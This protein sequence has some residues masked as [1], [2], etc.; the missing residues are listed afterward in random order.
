[1]DR[2]TRQQCD[3]Y[4]YID[5]SNIRLACAK[6]LGIRIDFV[7]LLNYLRK[8]YPN[9][10]DIRYYEGISSDDIK[11]RKMFGFLTQ[12]GYT[13]CELERKS[14]HSIDIEERKIKCQKCGHEWAEKLSREHKVMKSNVDVYLASDM[15]AQASLA[16]NP[17]NI[18]L[19]SCD[20]DY[21][22]AIKTALRLNQNVSVEV[23]ATP[24][25][26]NPS[27]N[28]LSTRLRK[29]VSVIPSTRFTILNIDD[30]RDKISC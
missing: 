19:V 21:A 15:V 12:K 25:V 20:G 30:V 2:Y 17:T 26:K 23:L 3:A 13:I 18:V 4:I 7:K 10:K 28:T 24:L 6:T 22:E 16:G 1:M 29:L 14:Y 5:V 8:R 9:I 27:R 11:K